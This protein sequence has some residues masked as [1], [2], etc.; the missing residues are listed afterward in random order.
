[1]PALPTALSHNHGLYLGALTFSRQEVSLRASQR[2]LADYGAAALKGLLLSE[3]F[4]CLAEYE[5]GVLA[6]LIR[7]RL[8]ADKILENI[9]KIDWRLYSINNAGVFSLGVR[10]SRRSA[11]VFI[12]PARKP[13]LR[14]RRSEYDATDDFYTPDEMLCSARR[15]K[16]LRNIHIFYAN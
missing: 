3:V 9:S 11:R 10:L 16:A 13:A 12:M 4:G 15:L 6:L 5:L 7:Y 2:H 14:S 8:S 1:M